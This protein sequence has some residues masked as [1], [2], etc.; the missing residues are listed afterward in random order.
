[1]SPAAGRD[2]E[3]RTE[4]P[5]YWL[6][7]SSHEPG[8][9]SFFGAMVSRARVTLSRPTLRR[10]E[11][12]RSELD[13]E[14]CVSVQTQTAKNQLEKSENWWSCCVS[15]RA[16]CPAGMKADR[17]RPE[18]IHRPVQDQRCA[19]E[20]VLNSA[21]TETRG[22]N[23]CMTKPSETPRNEQRDFKEARRGGRSA[24]TTS[25]PG[26]DAC[27]LRCRCSA[28]APW[29]S[30]AVYYHAPAW[31]QVGTKEHRDPRRRQ[32]CCPLGEHGRL[33]V[34]G[35][36]CGVHTAAQMPAMPTERPANTSE[37]N[38]AVRP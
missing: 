2:G 30:P 21:R 15:C 9:I 10:R 18:P 34:P 37:A 25:R 8:T 7:S 20:R 19:R 23:A 22:M 13:S 35:V 11:R 1:M 24:S 32:R 3:G 17:C 12:T 5:T 14:G 27:S 38:V 33:G 28:G 6:F 36:W 26:S 31:R 29:F 4:T 16:S